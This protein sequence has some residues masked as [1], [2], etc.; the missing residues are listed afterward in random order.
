MIDVKCNPRIKTILLQLAAADGYITLSDI[1]KELKVS[2]KTIMRDLPEA[3]KILRGLNIVLDKKTGAGLRL[4]AT[5]D[6]REALLSFLR[7]Q[8]AEIVYTPV[9]RLSA[10]TAHLLANQEPLKLFELTH[11][12]KVA[13]ST[14]SNDLDKLEPWFG[15]H[16]LVLIR[17]P[18]LGIYLQGNEQALRNA[19]LQFIHEN[20]DE[21]V[22]LGILHGEFS[23]AMEKRG[24]S[25]SHN[26]LCG[27]DAAHVFQIS[28]ILQSFESLQD[29]Q[30]SDNAYID[31]VLNLAL[32]I[33][34]IRQNCPSEIPPTLL[35]SLKNK[36]EYV[37]ACQLA[38]V[39]E[40]AFSLVIPSSE[41]AS[42]TM[43]LLGARNQYATVGSEIK[44]IDNFQ[45][46][47]L[48]AALIKVAE[49]ETGL[50]LGKNNKLMIGL[51]NHLG[52]SI[53][54]LKMNLVIRNPLLTE[55]NK[56]YPDLM[57]IGRKC[58]VII[59]KKIGLPLP[60][61]EI[62]Y[63]AMHLGSAIESQ[64]SVFRPIYKVAIACPAGLASSQMLATKLERE[65]NT[66][67]VIRLI[68]AI[69]VDEERLAEEGVRFII[70]TV[71]IPHCTIPV[72]TVSPRLLDIDK[73]TITNQMN[74]L[75]KADSIAPDTAARTYTFEER[76]SIL[77]HYSQACLEL[78]HTFFFRQD[79]SASTLAHL[80]DHIAD[81]CRPDEPGRRAVAEALRHREQYGSTILNEQK[82]LLLH[83][84]TDHAVRLQFGVTR[85]AQPLVIASA[86]HEPIAIKTAV[87]MLA[88]LAAEQ[89]KL[90]TISY[91]AKMLVERWN[92]IHTLHSGTP[93]AIKA[94]LSAILEEFFK[95]KNTMLLEE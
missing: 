71:A 24:F 59:A 84:R 29:K 89:Y 44:T 49:Q 75:G 25:A 43:Q 58:A 22:I 15:E 13:E 82:M 88:P 61:A 63:I 83:C 53:S 68:S 35:V 37:L 45:L 8:P 36:P 76:L 50:Q 48:A 46:V 72:V 90:E 74:L 11:K 1:A 3:E 5:S 17:K 47:Q 7:E 62:A 6:D 40:Q 23:N 42:I 41:I 57:A 55:M 31:L 20:V 38:A 56:Y 39:L 26:L 87:L 81:D 67:K 95:E 33:Q 94:E 73:L 91:L 2:A 80:I 70:S 85:L 66:L 9:E 64:H 65:Y 54:R 60:D 27:I 32:G 28:Q 34:R 18:G 79:A 93:E 92:F 16:Q 51:V 10:I 52:P 19:V 4:S 78:L 21:N 14:I 69:H 12:L 77:T 86:E 30:L